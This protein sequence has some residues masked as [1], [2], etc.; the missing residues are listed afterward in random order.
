[1]ACAMGSAVGSDLPA[2]ELRQLECGR[3]WC[4]LGA[5]E[6]GRWGGPVAAG[7]VVGQGVA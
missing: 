2:F 5:K 6:C 4:K 7:R 3:A 1:M